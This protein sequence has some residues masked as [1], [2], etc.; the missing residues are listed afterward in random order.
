[1]RVAKD[2]G[3]RLQP[4]SGAVE[5][6]KSDSRIKG[7]RSY[8]IESKSTVN[9]TMALEL[10]WLSKISQEA[11]ASGSTP[12]V[13]VSFVDAAGRP[14]SKFNADWVLIPKWAFEELK[15]TP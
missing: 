7:A 5:G 8:R 9:V 11:L 4:A 13:T 6:Y 3:A 15:D 1:M 14:R 2:L 10:Q 12:V